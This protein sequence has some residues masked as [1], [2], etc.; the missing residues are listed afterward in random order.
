MIAVMSDTPTIG[1]V[2][3]GA[4]GLSYAYFLAGAATVVLKTR[5]GQQADSINEQGLQVTRQGEARP[6]THP[7]ATANFADLGGCDLVIVAVK[8][9]D[10][11]AVAQELDQVVRPDAQIVSLQ[12]G[13]EGFAA[14]R[15]GMSH[16]GRVFAAVTYIGAS[17][18][19]QR[20]VILGQSHRT[21]VD[22]QATVLVNALQQTSF[23]PEPT[24]NIRQAIWD[25]AAL[26]TAQNALSAITDLTVQQM[27]ATQ[28]CLEVAGHILEEFQQVATAEGI[29]FQDSLL[30]RVQKNW[31]GGDDFYPSMW[32]DLHKGNRTEI[33]ALNGAIAALGQKHNIAT[34][35]NAMITNLIKARE[36]QDA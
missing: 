34:P 1:I 9:Y 17:R 31:A 18:S 28:A 36:S 3:A 19:D 6:V 21:V 25:K 30:E 29:T 2:G 16:P 8:S 13:L 12:N 11:Q 20:S 26:N 27:L 22:Q 10:T 24:A 5:A 35:Y 23:K 33:D 14:L 32:Q 7:R 4:V 15:A